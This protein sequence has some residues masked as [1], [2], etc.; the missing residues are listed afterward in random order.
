MMKSLGLYIY[1]IVILNSYN[2]FFQIFLVLTERMSHDVLCLTKLTLDIPM[3]THVY[4][5][6]DYY[7]L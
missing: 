4:I 2:V 1:C 3:F 7:Y 5:I 6:N